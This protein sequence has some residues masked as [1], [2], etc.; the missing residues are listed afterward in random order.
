MARDADADRQRIF[1]NQ[2]ANSGP[3][4]RPQ[5]P[6]GG[7]VSTGQPDSLNRPDR[8]RMA[9]H[10]PIVSL[11]TAPTGGPG[12][13]IRYGKPIVLSLS[14]PVRADQPQRISSGIPQPLRTGDVMDLNGIPERRV[15]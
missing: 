6:V 7:L 2:M 8:I 11:C 5:S 15:D 9:R 13:I 1:F 10:R 12:Q 4:M 14:E 3:H